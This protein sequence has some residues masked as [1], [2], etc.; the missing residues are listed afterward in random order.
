MTVLHRWLEKSPTEGV[1]M[2]QLS[3]PAPW[4]PRL[5]MKVLLSKAVKF[6]LSISSPPEPLTASPLEITL[7]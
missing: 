6:V 3:P 1:C 7:L 5:L 2:G 4:V